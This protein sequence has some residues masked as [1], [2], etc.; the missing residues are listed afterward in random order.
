MSSQVAKENKLLKK[1]LREI[2]VLA[3][4]QHLDWMHFHELAMAEPFRAEVEAQA[5]AA[6]VVTAAFK[7]LGTESDIKGR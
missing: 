2:E 3:W 1:A 4:R 5:F 6:R 7:V